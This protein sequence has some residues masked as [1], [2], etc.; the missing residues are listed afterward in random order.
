[1]E[2][3]AQ[4]RSED[5]FLS[6]VDRW[7]ANSHPHLA[8]GRGDDCAELL[9]PGRLAV[10]T[11][12]FLEDIH[13]RRRYFS[14]E[15]LGHKA[16][17][18]NLSDLAAAGAMPLAFSLGL[19]AP[20]PFPRKDAEGILS[21]MAGLAGRHNL[22]LSG[23]DLSRAD[24]LGFAVTS[25]GGS[26]TDKTPFLRRTPVLP[27]HTLFYCGSLGLARVGLALL[28]QYGRPALAAYPAACLAHL[29]PEP[30]L[31]EGRALAA[32]P[33]RAMD[34]SDGLAR[35]LPR[36]LA[37]LG[38]VLEIP[39]ASLHPELRHFAAGQGLDPAMLA[40]TGGEEY[41]LLGAAPPELFPVLS[42]TLGAAPAVLLGTVREEPGIILNGRTVSGRGFDHFAAS[43]PPHSPHAK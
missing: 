33:C 20:A 22:A 2:T 19:M 10:S 11:D 18:V 31:A 25:W 23:G 13:F 24:K 35:D 12:L 21:S 38:A 1:M 32:F 26:A 36:M 37:G 17:A 29:R 34:I 5:D 7:F 9:C 43:G 4:I 30:L 15:D 27:G 16:L 28:E 42:T 3:S 40:F 8:L 14:P 41:G 39:E 6:L